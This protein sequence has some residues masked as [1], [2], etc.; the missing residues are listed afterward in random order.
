MIARFKNGEF[1]DGLVEGIGMIGEKL[2]A[3]FPY[4][5]GDVNELSDEVSLG[6]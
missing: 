5:K 6:E 2:Q 4:Q 1:T 3:Y